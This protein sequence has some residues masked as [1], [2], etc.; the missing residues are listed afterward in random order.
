MYS[1][2]SERWLTQAAVTSR[3]YD[4]ICRTAA[5]RMRAREAMSYDTGLLMYAIAYYIAILAGDLTLA[6][7]EQFSH[8]RRAYHLGINLGQPFFGRS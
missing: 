8:T 2:D 5:Q 6:P 4:A 3:Y 1:S 7:E